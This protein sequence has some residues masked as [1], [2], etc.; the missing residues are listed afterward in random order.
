MHFIMLLP[1]LLTPETPLNHPY[2]AMLTA[3]RQHWEMPSVAMVMVHGTQTIGPFTQGCDAQTLFPLGSCTKAIT[4]SLMAQLVYDGKLSWDDPITQHMPTFTLADA[5]HAK[6]LTLRDALSHRTGV[7]SHDYLWYHAPWDRAEVFRRMAYLRPTHP[8]RSHYDYSTLMYM[9]AG[10]VAENAGGAPWE[11]MIRERTLKPAGMTETLTNSLAAQKVSNR[12]AAY[13]RQ[14]NK[15][16]PMAEYVLHEPNAAGSMYTTPNDAALW[17]MWMLAHPGLLHET[18]KS[19]TPM[20]KEGVIAKTYP[21]SSRIDYALGWVRF[22]YLGRIVLAHGGVMDG[23]R[24]LAV[25]LPS[26]NAGFVI[27]SNIHQT[28]LNIALMYT[29]LDRIFVP[30]KVTDWNRYFRDLEDQEL[31]EKSEAFERLRQ[32]RRLGTRLSAPLDR[33][34]GTYTHPAYGDAT[35]TVVEQSLRWKWS[36]FNSELAHFENDVFRITAGHFENQF[37]EF[38][39]RSGT[40]DAIRFLGEVFERKP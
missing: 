19:H 29:I 40:P 27:F 5:A 16:V 3:A 38:R 10:Q 17:L 1:W 24:T 32:A 8:N 9:V 11:T 21:R 15:V 31:R 22:D 39:N 25:L 36:G 30:T 13:E 33:F 28:K 37:I 6:S 18:W 23:F 26:R 7:P 35:F 4:A 14:G 12:A 34:A 2:D 20:P